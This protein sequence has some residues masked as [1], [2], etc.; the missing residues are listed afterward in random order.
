MK[1]TNHI[2]LKF[3]EY[4][5]EFISF[6]G[7]GCSPRS[8]EYALRSTL[9]INEIN[10]PIF[11]RNLAI[12]LGPH[13]AVHILKILSSGYIPTL[14]NILR[15]DPKV[16]EYLDK[17]F[18]RQDVLLSVIDQIYNFI[19]G[20]ADKNVNLKSDDVSAI[21][22]FLMMVQNEHRVALFEKIRGSKYSVYFGKYFLKNT[23]LAE[24][25]YVKRATAA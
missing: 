18:E 6:D 1:Y 15:R 10:D 7:Q 9:S 25:L 16:F 5:P 13:S 3:L 11:L 23:R 4:C 21:V 19:T 22:E 24:V 2:L 8:F 17:N 20:N 14:K 12:E